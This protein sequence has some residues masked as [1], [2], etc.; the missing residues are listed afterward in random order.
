L[1]AVFVEALRNGLA[2]YVRAI[3]DPDSLAAIR[4]TLLVTAIAVPANVV[5]GVAAAWAIATFE[6]KGKTF[7]ITLIDLPFS[8]SPVVAGLVYVLLFG[9]SS[10]L[11]PI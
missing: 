10:F 7:L 1:L 8:I 2:A 11:G 9:A 4:L 6:F 5:F 3:G